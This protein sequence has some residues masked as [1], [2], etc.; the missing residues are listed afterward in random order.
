MKK[1]RALALLLLAVLSLSSVA[2]VLGEPAGASSPLVASG[3]TWRYHERGWH[4]GSAWVNRGFD[5]ARWPAG[6]AQLGYGDGDEATRIRSGIR[7]AYF[8]HSFDVADPAR[9]SGSLVIDLVRDDGA[10]VYL[11]GVEVVRSN[12]PTGRVGNLTFAEKTVWGRAERATHSYTVP[13]STLVKGRNVVAV[14]V[15]QATRN[16]SDISF[17]LSMRS[18]G[19]A[20]TPPPTQSVPRPSG[21]LMP[22][23]GAYLGL[24]ASNR[25]DRHN[26]DAYAS[27][28]SKH[29]SKAGRTLDIGHHYYRWG[30]IPPERWSE[31]WHVDND[32]I[33]M[34][35]WASVSTTEVN[36]GRH[37]AYIRERAR[38]IDEFGEQVFLRWFWEADG[39]WQRAKA[40]SPTEYQKAWRR[41]HGIFDDL[42]ADN[43]VWVWCP[44]AWGFTTGE[45]QKYYPGDAYVDWICADGY[46][47]NKK[48]DWRSF[49]DVY[50]DFYE[51]G[52]TRGKPM[53]LGEIGSVEGLP[54]PEGPVVPRHAA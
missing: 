7:T 24:Y 44:T 30:D 50:A 19:P 5:D 8:R 21:A 29:E 18:G 41:I 51:W 22:D 42:G 39:D 38:A 35:S 52:I 33:P 23:E 34:I 6:R 4:P 2:T 47:W 54:R 9:L 46:N 1:K 14:E 48:G 15:H 28:Y 26:M 17:D 53:M 10:V 36:A 20:P 32:R 11:N 31:R 13:T 3:T 16:S 12:M 43:A 45:A 40:V 27:V 37:D 49:D 25:T